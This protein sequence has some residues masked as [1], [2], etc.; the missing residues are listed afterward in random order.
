ML[1]IVK[2]VGLWLQVAIHGWSTREVCKVPNSCLHYYGCKL[3]KDNK[4]EAF[5][6]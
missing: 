5:F 2:N 4:V 1:S 3:I 6:C